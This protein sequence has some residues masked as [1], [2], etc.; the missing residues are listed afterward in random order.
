MDPLAELVGESPQSIH[1]GRAVRQ[2]VRRLGA[3]APEAI[4]VWIVSA[5][6]ADLQV[7]VRVRSLRE[8]LYHRLAVLTLRPPALRERGNDVL[9][10]AERFLARACAD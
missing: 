8:D 5:T 10:L 1:R 9:V 3:T 7:A 2:A 4:D 6:N